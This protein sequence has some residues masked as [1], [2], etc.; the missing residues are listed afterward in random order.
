M[1]TIQTRSCPARQ[2]AGDGARLL[3]RYGEPPLVAFN[4][5]TGTDTFNHNGT[6]ADD[7][8]GISTDG[9]TWTALATFGDGSN[10]TSTSTG[11][12]TIDLSGQILSADSAI[13]FVVSQLGN[14]GDYFRVD[15]VQVAFNAD[16][17]GINYN[18]SYTEQQT[19]AAVHD[20][21][22][23]RSDDTTIVSKR[24]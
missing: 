20:T 21:T 19:P 4:G 10:S 13:R 6:D 2:D 22:D 7:V 11:A 3:D 12:Q 15:N 23:H 17:D 5:G 1:V 8:F 9:I 14:T 16:I 24:S 18:S